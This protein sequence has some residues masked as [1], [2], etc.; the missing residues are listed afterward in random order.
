MSTIEAFMRSLL[1]SFNAEGPPPEA[2]QP[3]G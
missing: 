2:E 1:P 3:P